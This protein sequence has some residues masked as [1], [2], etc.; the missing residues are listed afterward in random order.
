MEVE[1]GHKI[2]GWVLFFEFIGTANL[3]YAI[4]TSTESGMAP[5]GA[6]L[7]IMANICIFGQVTGGHFNPAITL[8]VL[9]A[10]GRANFSKNIL[11]ALSLMAVQIAGA[12]TGCGAAF[13]SQYYL[14]KNSK[15]FQLV[16][17]I[18]TLQPFGP[19]F[20]DGYR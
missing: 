20:D 9:I 18:A 3:L 10:E 7:T 6:G 5:Y 19:T 12:F 13:L 4:N 11:F 16:P 2:K 14:D 17:G 8:A 1:G 15:N